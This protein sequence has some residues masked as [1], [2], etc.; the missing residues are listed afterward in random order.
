MKKKIP[1]FFVVITLIF[2]GHSVEGGNEEKTKTEILQLIEQMNLPQGSE[3]AEFRIGYSYGLQP[4]PYLIDLLKSE[5]FQVKS[6]A[7]S[8]M[9]RIIRNNF[10]KNEPVPWKEIDLTLFEEK[11]QK[12]LEEA[13]N[14][15]TKDAITH[16]ETN[17]RIESIRFIAMMGTPQGISVL[18][19]CLEDKVL[20][21]RKWAVYYLSHFGKNYS[22]FKVL[23][24][25]EPKTPEEY[26][27][28]LYNPYLWVESIRKLREF[29]KEALPVLI[30]CSN[31]EE[32]EVRLRAMMLLAEMKAEE[33]I[34]IFTRYLKEET[35]DETMFAIQT[36]CISGLYNIGTEEAIKQLKEYGLKHKNP[37]IRYY[38]AKTLIKTNKEEVMPVL[39]DLVEQGNSSMKYDIAL[40]LIENKEKEGIEILIGLLKD[41]KYLREAES[42]LEGMTGQ[43][44]GGIPPV[45]SKKMLEEYT[46]KWESWWEKNKDT[47]QFPKQDK[48]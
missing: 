8:A 4:L 18:E 11:Y 3:N 29:G 26:G 1:I 19:K 22:Y 23:A 35:K 13:M 30:S 42:W 14:I 39:K 20:L 25:E 48:Q 2:I 44:F 16:P 6:R 40:F 9:S 34:P 27:K 43:K 12:I 46:K 31:S 7:Y 33:A 24:G 17:V 28:Y 21:V 47:F 38:T 10:R 32:K 36:Y 5:N 41:K 45:V 37:D 15:A